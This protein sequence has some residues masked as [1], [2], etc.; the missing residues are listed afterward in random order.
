MTLGYDSDVSE[1]FGGVSN[2]DTFYDHL[3][4][5]HGALVREK[6]RSVCIITHNAF[7]PTYLLEQPKNSII[8]LTHSIGGVFFELESLSIYFQTSETNLKSVIGRTCRQARKNNS[9]CLQCLT[10]HARCCSKLIDL[11]PSSKAETYIRLLRLFPFSTRIKAKYWMTASTRCHQWRTKK[12][13][14]YCPSGEVRYSLTHYF[15]HFVPSRE[16]SLNASARTSRNLQRARKVVS[17][18]VR[19]KAYKSS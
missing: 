4:D 11:R 1:F 7:H 13:D 19:N 3:G 12:M 10:E 5:L 2:K 18:G 9:A 16:A 15:P 6:M 14:K 8:F 17:S